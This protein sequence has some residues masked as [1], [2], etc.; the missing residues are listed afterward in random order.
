MTCRVRGGMRLVRACLEAIQSR[1]DELWDLVEDVLLTGCSREH[2]V[3][4]EELLLAIDFRFDALTI[5]SADQ[6]RHG[7]R[8]YSTEYPYLQNRLLH[9][10]LRV[11]LPI[12]HRVASIDK[13][14]Y[15]MT[16]W[17]FC[18]FWFEY[19]SRWSTEAKVRWVSS[20]YEEGHQKN[21]QSK[22]DIESSHCP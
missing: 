16:A 20:C 13:T 3:K 19:H 15:C 6:G 7:V 21:R 1:L 10:W 9:F 5:W 4:L 8:F 17:Y 22:G 11:A 14:G 18:K 2:P 12:P